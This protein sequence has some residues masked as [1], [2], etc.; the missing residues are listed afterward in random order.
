MDQ[1]SVKYIGKRAQY[2][3]GTYGTRIL[4]IQ[5]ESRL[6]P[7]DKAR[8]MLKHPDVYVPGEADAVAAVI[9]EEQAKK[10]DDET[11]D[12]R[13]AIAIMDKVALE[14]YAKTNFRVN[15][16]RRKNVGALRAEVTG[17]VDRF[18]AL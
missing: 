10:P 4:F 1:V 11:Q 6:V 8:L 9:P 7:I 13:D 3:D 18:G 2:T 5:G 14:A 12:M 17:L 15:I 16:D